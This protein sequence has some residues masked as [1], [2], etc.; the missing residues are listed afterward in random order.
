MMNGYLDRKNSNY[1]DSYYMSFPIDVEALD[2]EY[3]VTCEMPGVMKENIHISFS[4]GILTICAK[5]KQNNHNKYLIHE[6]SFMNMKREINFGDIDEDS[7]SAK[8][9][10]GLLIISVKNKALKP[11]KTIEIM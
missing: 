3:I 5:K 7:I 2:D 1:D 9:N 8:L 4:D 11:K 6:R 10:D